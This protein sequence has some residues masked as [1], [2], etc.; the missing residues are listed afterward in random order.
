MKICFA[1][2]NKKKLEEVKA[3]LPS[4]FTLLSLA[5]IGCR[6]ELAETQDT[7]EGNALQKAQYVYDKFGVPCFADD[8]GLEVPSLGGEPGVYSARYAG[9]ARN[10][11][12]NIQLLLRK[13]NTIDDRSAWF[14]TVIALLGFGSKPEFFEGRVDGNILREKR[15]EQGFGYDPIFVPDGFDQTFAEMALSQKNAISH[16][17]IA[18]RKLVEYLKGVQ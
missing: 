16:R 17:G 12:D 4:G 11:E 14:R 5:D 1:T 3:L 10:D 2:N 13:L 6:E 9:P 18:V 8:S 15:G 7:F